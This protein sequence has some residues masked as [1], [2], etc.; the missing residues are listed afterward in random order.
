ME[1]VFSYAAVTVVL[2]FCDSRPVVFF[3]GSCWFSGVSSSCK[4]MFPLSGVA[5]CFLCPCAP[6][7]L[8]LADLCGG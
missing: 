4:C 7:G 3:A 8:V 1:G 6:S 2:C 5:V